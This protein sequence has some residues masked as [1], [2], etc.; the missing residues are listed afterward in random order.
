MGLS[1][2]QRRALAIVPKCTGFLSMMG[3][4]IIILDVLRNRKKRKQTYSRIMCAMSCFDFIT[5]TMYALSTWPIP[6]GSGPLW[7]AGT[8]ETCTAQ[9]FFIQL[10]LAAPM[11]NLCLALYYVFIIKYRWSDYKLASAE[12]FIHPFIGFTAIG[13]AIAGLPL[14]IYNSANVWCW[15]APSDRMNNPDEANNVYRWAFYYVELWII[16][17]LVTGIMGLVVTSVTQTTNKSAT[18]HSRRTNK[19]AQVRM[20]ALCYVS[21]FYVTWVFPTTLRIL[22]TIGTTVPYPIF[23]CAV[24]FTPCQGFFNCLIYLRP[25]FLRLIKKKPQRENQGASHFFRFSFWT[26]H[27]S[28]SLRNNKGNAMPRDSSYKTMRVSTPEQ[29]NSDG[30]D[31]NE[32]IDLEV[33]LAEANRTEESEE[34]L[35]CGRHPRTI[36]GSF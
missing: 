9:G 30:S 2:A 24:I 15:I 7:A 4:F 12:R 33:E 25:R 1:L 18:Y 23:L 29:D 31:D 10:S 13:I 21:A 14:K 34:V 36:F 32:N 11:Y 27:I 20:Q 22:Q 28:N 17:I 35:P 8:Q 16:I 26:S 19:V 6:R 5:S 3:S